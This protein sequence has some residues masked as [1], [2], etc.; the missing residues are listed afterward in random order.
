MAGIPNFDG[1]I[2]TGFHA[3]T[4]GVNSGVGST[5]AEYLR[6]T[7]I[8][9]NNQYVGKIQNAT[10]NFDPTAAF[11]KWVTG[12][13]TVLQGGGASAWFQVWQQELDQDR[14]KTDA[15][16][17][18]DDTFE[19][20]GLGSLSGKIKEYIV[21]GYTGDTIAL[22]L[23]E[24]P[25]YKTRF[26]GNEMRRQKGLA[27]LSPAEYIGIE[28]QYKN[29][30]RQ[31]GLPTG[32]YDNMSDLAGYIGN[33]VSA[34]EMDGRMSL[35]RKT[36]RADNLDTRNTYN[37][38]YAS[39][40]TEGDAIAAILDPARALPELERRQRSSAIGGAAKFYQL[41]NDID[42]G[43]AEFLGDKG[44]SEDDANRGF[45][46]MNQFLNPTKKFAR[47]Y[48]QD[49]QTVDA[50]SEVF[51]NSGAARQKREGLF[52]REIAEFS[53]SQAASSKSF[54]QGRY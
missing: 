11:E 49:Y 44:V 3:Q 52:N 7:D 1:N 54:S 37:Q 10:Q 50:Q 19:R 31:Y 32:M 39:G 53:G 40:L 48:G 20:Y 18:L 5:P 24:T 8:F 36:V 21:G 9:Y 14:Q 34:Q 15:F 27:V 13:G 30:F 51:F 25:E 41:G 22:M 43:V 6:W 4:A 17:F 28:D 46:A 38:W 16:A 26:A 12:Q 2:G 29:L 33:D 47:R 45:A 42:R 35:A 23:A